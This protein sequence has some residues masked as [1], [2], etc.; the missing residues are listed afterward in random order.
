MR[1]RSGIGGERRLAGAGEP[2]EQ[3][4]VAAGADVRRAVH[5]EHALLRQ[6]V[7]HHREHRLLQLTG[8][9]RA[10]DEDHALGEIEHDEGAGA[11]A[12]ARRIG[13]ELRRVQ[14]GEV[15]REGRE[16]LLRPGG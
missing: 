7:V 8:V 3:R 6:V 13:L 12:V 10:A 16:L 1:E 2:E 11:R 9:A 14:H 5:G 4:G 15:R